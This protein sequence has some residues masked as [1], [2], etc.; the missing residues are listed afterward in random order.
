[1]IKQLEKYEKD[2]LDSW[3]ELKVE[4]QDAFCKELAAYFELNRSELT[5]YCLNLK[6]KG[7]SSLSIVYEA[8]S[9]YSF[10]F[11]DFILDEVKRL[12]LLAKQ[13]KI[14]PKR[15]EV[16]EDFDLDNL[17]E[18]DYAIYKRIIEFLMGTLSHRN[19][20]KF[21]LALLDLI[22]D[23]LIYSE[24]D[25]QLDIWENQVESFKKGA[26]E[27]L[28]KEF[29]PKKFWHKYLKMFEMPKL[30][31]QILFFIGMIGQLIAIY[32]Y[33]KT[34]IEI[35]FSLGIYIVVGLIGFIA[36]NTKLKSVNSKTFRKFVSSI[37]GFGGTAIFLFLFLNYQ[38]ASKEIDSARYQILEKSSIMG[39]KYNRSKKQPT[40][41]ILINNTK[42]EIVFAHSQTAE[43]KKASY[44][45]IESSKGLFGF[46]IIR[47]RQLE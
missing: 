16:L 12:V 27:G 31:F 4:E 7:F 38:L 25:S 2:E 21:N 47:N 3:Y 30:S 34:V 17:V 1:M 5:N 39:S 18:K 8:V 33:R 6:P 19:S 36:L 22:D 44:I 29:A 43:V 15:L 24:D 10:Q 20:D 37:I 23:Y 9:L 13:E 26:S 40:A 42:K 35:E 14:K 32:L 11:N 46:D 45:V 41:Y 28:K